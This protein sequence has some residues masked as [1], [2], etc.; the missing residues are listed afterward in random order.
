MQARVVPLYL[1]L[2][3]NNNTVDE[4]IRASR[5]GMVSGTPATALAED[6]FFLD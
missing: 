4:N 3:L 5:R 6:N 2:S 1:D